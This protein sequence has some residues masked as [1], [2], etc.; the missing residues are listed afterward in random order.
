MASKIKNQVADDT[1]VVK[2]Q[3]VEDAKDAQA[4]INVAS[5][6]A[7]DQALQVADV[8][9]GASVNVADA[10]AKTVEQW[11]DPATR[12]QEIESL[13]KQL[14]SELDKA[15]ERGGEVRRQVTDQFTEQ[16]RKARERVEPAYKERVEPV[17]NRVRDRSGATAEK[18]TAE[19][20]TAKK[21]TVKA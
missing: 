17:V 13:R 10:V 3:A 6:A 20:T 18:T 4:R 2:G 5:R 11:R 21:A 14:T 15:G 19:K 16:V 8:V 7:A 9:T 12:S 1:E